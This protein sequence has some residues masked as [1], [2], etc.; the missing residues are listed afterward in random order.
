MSDQLHL[1]LHPVRAERA[2]D[3][4]RFVSDV[5][6]PAV[7]AQRPDLDGRWRVMRASEAADG[8][9]TFAFLLEGG[10]LDEDWDLGVLL[11]AEYGEEEAE[12]LLGEWAETF[13][14]LRPWADAAVA[15]G[16]ENNQAVWTLEPLTGR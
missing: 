7:R 12:R 15:D 3:F 2:D 1:V 10:S 11:P 4:E 9:V 14:P 13:A 6:M 16:E 5:V 8:I